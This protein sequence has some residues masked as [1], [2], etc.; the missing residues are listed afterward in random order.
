ML[1]A[2]VLLLGGCGVPVDSEPRDLTAPALPFGSSGPARDQLGTA[3]ERLYLVRDGELSR[4][5][6]QVPAPRTPAQM[7]QDLLAG[8]T[9]KEHEDGL[10]SALSTMQVE[11]ITVVQRRAVIAIGETAGQGARSDEILA[12][13]QIVCTL[14]SQG[15]EV[16]TVAF[17]SDGRQLGVPRGDGSLSADPLTIADYA[18]L[19]G[20]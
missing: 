14:T 13:G 3:V 16:G 6:R 20:S 2:A 4:V 8:P 18:G 15:A 1:L 7:V 9:A 19:I 5:I 11:G 10:S 12:Y 17:T